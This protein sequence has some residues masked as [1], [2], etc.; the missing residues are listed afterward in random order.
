MMSPIYMYVSNTESAV[1]STAGSILLLLAVVVAI[2]S[3][4]FIVREKKGR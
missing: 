1:I 4:A 3:M 2:V